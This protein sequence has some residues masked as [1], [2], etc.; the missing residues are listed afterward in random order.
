MNL[1]K[2]KNSKDITI[3]I[4]KTKKNKTQEK[5]VEE[6]VK[7]KNKKNNNNSNKNPKIKKG[8][9]QKLVFPISQI[10][11]KIKLSKKANYNLYNISTEDINFLIKLILKETHNFSPVKSKFQK[12][13]IFTILFLI[14]FILSIFYFY[15]KKVYLGIIFI[16]IFIFLGFIYL[17]SVRKT[18]NKNYKKCQQK[19][20]SLTDYINRKLLSKL[21]YYLLVDSSFRFIGIY[22]IPGSVRSILSLRDHNIEVKKNLE[23]G[24]IDTMKKKENYEEHPKYDDFMKNML[25]KDIKDFTERNNNYN[26]KNDII[27]KE[28]VNMNNR[29][30]KNNKI[31]FNNFFK[32]KSNN[33][34]IDQDNTVEISLTNKERIR[35]EYAQKIKYKK[36]KDD[37]FD[38]SE[39][40]PDY[41]PNNY[42]VN[43]SKINN[44]SIDKFKSYFGNSFNGIELITN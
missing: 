15:K 12:N 5:V 40:Y 2:E 25:L 38:E 30:L 8:R 23:G 11:G 7:N 17:H 1:V 18:I 41:I 44:K 43:N 27:K 42:E 9:F 29:T 20:F 22:V 28:N 6:K 10:T 24:T 37:S 16:L 21:G 14:S 26:K 3:I 35:L 31:K 36:K 4:K 32:G 33:D 19:L 13:L 34:L 39:N